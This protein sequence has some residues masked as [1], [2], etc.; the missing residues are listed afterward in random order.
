M[1]M[2]AEIP[3]SLADLIRGRV[4]E[5]ARI[6]YKA[7]WNPES[8]L[9]TICAFANDFSNLGGGYL[10]IGA[11]EENGRAA[12]PL[13]GIDPQSIDSLNKKLLELCN[14]IQPRYLPRSAAVELDSHWAFV[15]WVPGGSERPYKCPVSLSRSQTE[16]GYYVRRMASTVKANTS[17]EKELFQLSEMA[18]F[19]DRFNEKATVGDLQPLLM[20]AYLNAIHSNLAARA[21]TLPLNELASS[22]HIIGGPTEDLRP[23]NVGLMFFN[24]RPENFFR[25]A[26]IEI[27][28]KPDPTGQQM[29][30]KTFTGPLDRQLKDALQYIQN[31]ILKEKIVKIPD[32]PEAQRTMNYPLVAVR[33]ALVNAVYHKSYQIAEPITVT[34]T[35]DRMEITSL[36]GPDRSIS[37]RDLTQHHLSCRHYRNRRIGDFLKELGLAEGRNT[38]IPNMIGA[39]A[40]NGS[41]LPIFET[42]AERTY[43]TVILPI[44]RSFSVSRLAENNKRRSRQEILQQI[45]DLL[46]TRDDLS[47]KELAELMGYPT[48]P[49][50][51]RLCVELL[52]ADGTLEFTRPAQKRSPRQRIRLRQPH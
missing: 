43:F 51:L 15:I 2:D 11:E 17:E 24:D 10:I 33:E 16:H 47:M 8:V 14:R 13:S 46:R 7:N 5:S 4:V 18:P 21:P 12:E 19:D 40:A 42:D 30:E 32:Q 37:D 9:H 36:P 35:A 28:D 29:T 41:D 49:S 23:L 38:G 52:I 39:L 45:V 27:V 31:Y 50:S 25:C 34:V 44:S 22:L 20:T 26:R 1:S 48:V 3:L 6:E